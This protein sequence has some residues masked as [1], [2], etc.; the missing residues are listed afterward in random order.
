MIPARSPLPRRTLVLLAALLPAASAFAADPGANYSDV[1]P[2][3]AGGSGN[4]G[5]NASGSSANDSGADDSGADNSSTGNSTIDNSSTGN[6]GAGGAETSNP[7][8]SSDLLSNPSEAGAEGLERI[9][10][11]PQ[12]SFADDPAGIPYSAVLNTTGANSD[13]INILGE[14]PINTDSLLYTKI[15]PAEGT[16][17]LSPGSPEIPIPF[18]HHGFEP[19]DADLKAGPFYVK[20]HSLDGLVLYDDNFNASQTDRRSEVLVLL[21]LNMTV[22]AQLTEDLQFVVSGYLGYLPLQNQFGVQSNL[23]GALGILATGPILASQ[24]VYDVD[25]GGWP[26]RFAD[27]FQ[28][29]TGFYSNGVLDNFALFQGNYLERQDSG[30]YIFADG[31]NAQQQQVSD[32]YS[33]DASLLVFSNAVS[34]VTDRL[35]PGDIRLTVQAEHED[36]WYNQDNRGL[37]SSRDDFY[38]SAVSERENERFKPFVS[39]ELSYVQG[40]PGVTQ[41]VLGG[42]FG[43]ID[44]Q[45]FLRAQAGYFVTANGHQDALYDVELKHTAGPYTYEE[46]ELIRNLTYFD[47]EVY[48]AEYYRI[49]QILGPTLTADAFVANANYRELLNNGSSSYAEDLGGANLLWQMGPKTTLELTGIA[50]QIRY[51]GQ[52]NNNALIARAIATRTITDSLTMQLLY[53]YQRVTSNRPG[54]SYFENIVY[55]RIIKY[56]Q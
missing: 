3:H 53:E 8:E 27:D 16:L 49:N 5:S 35:L 20:F 31:R 36:L 25:A 4:D 50:E 10:N 54:E 38:V 32:I 9:H 44:D 1:P 12:G 2:V 17:L 13:N 55:F 22:Y 14:R 19:E 46:V 26:I 15:G 33:Q 39:Y 29:T 45:I 30:T 56:F 52:F 23:Y 7:D 6:P 47:Q 28:V 48:T 40:G 51:P 11:L 43:P 37:P 21:R 24:L 34:A 42:F 18:L 41:E